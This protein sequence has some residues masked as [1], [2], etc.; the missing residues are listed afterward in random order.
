MKMIEIYVKQKR[1]QFSTILPWIGLTKISMSKKRAAS[2][3]PNVNCALASIQRDLTIQRSRPYP[4]TFG[5]RYKIRAVYVFLNNLHS[6]QMEFLKMYLMTSFSPRLNLVFQLSRNRKISIQ[7]YLSP[8][9][10]IFKYNRE[11]ICLSNILLLRP[12]MRQFYINFT[13]L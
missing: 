1:K 10:I 5:A 2:F 6:I 8:T 3:V 12:E 9:Q 11:L 7:T 4:R 13:L